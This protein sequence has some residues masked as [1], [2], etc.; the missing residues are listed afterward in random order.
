MTA[1]RDLRSDA[2]QAFPIYITAVAALLFLALALFA[3]GQAGATRN[4]GQTAADAAALAAAQD[5]RDQLRKGFLEAIANGSVW[6]DLLNGRGIGTGDACER[7]QWFAQQNG[8]DLTGP[9]CVPGYLPTS[10][11]VTVRTQ[12]PVGKT[13]IPGTETKHA[14]AM[15]KAVVTPRCTAEPPAPPTKEPDDVGQGGGKGGDGGKDD[16]DGGKDDG[17]G[18]KDDGKDDKPPIDLRCDGLDLTIDPTRLDLF[19]DAK[20]LFSVHLAD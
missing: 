8:A 20:D 14:T 7:A 17:D 15:A 4:G 10:F 11:T 6:D 18:G 9:G 2:G 19:P 13:V 1:R 3:V 5:Y 16:G 12:K